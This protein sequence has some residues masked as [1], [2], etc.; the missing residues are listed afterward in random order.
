[1]AIELICPK[2]SRRLRVGDS[3]A[4]KHARCPQ[5]LHVFPIEDGGA[6]EGESTDPASTERWLMRGGDQAIY[7][8]V[9]KT[10]LDLWVSEGRLTAETKVRQ[11]DDPNWHDA[12]SLYPHLSPTHASPSSNPYS[13]SAGSPNPYASPVIT[14]RPRAHGL[15][16]PHRGATILVLGILGLM[17][18]SCACLIPGICAWYM[19]SEDLNAMRAGRM[20]PSGQGITMAGMVLG[21]IGTILHGM[22]YLFN[23]MGR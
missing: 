5:C 11:E 10:E 17:A 22:I 19:G 13:D 3:D 14:P 21:I 6:A 4:G 20:D 16:R 12:V 23:L 7:G 15:A 8:P 18:N 9:N 1:M 2:C